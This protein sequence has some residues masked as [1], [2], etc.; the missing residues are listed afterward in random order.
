[1]EGDGFSRRQA[2]GI[3][4]M[5]FIVAMFAAILPRRWWPP[6]ERHLPVRQ[7][8]VMSGIA[9]FLLAIA[10][11]LPAFLAFAQANAGRAIDMMLE[12]TGWRSPTTGASPVSVEAAQA[13]WVGGFPA[14]FVFAFFTPIGLLATYLAFTGWF[15]AISPVF[16]DARGDPLLTMIDAVAL[17][18]RG[19]RDERRATEARHRLEGE[20]VA[21]R[22]MSGASAGIPG[23]EIV[24]VTSSRVGRGRVRDHAGEVVPDRFARRTPHAE[25]PAHALSAQC[26]RPDGGAAEGDSLRSARDN[27]RQTSAVTSTS[28]RVEC[29]FSLYCTGFF[30]GDV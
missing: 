16:D 10:I 28:R 23:A 24:V 3:K 2:R 25:R 29:T 21:D 20:E 27:R 14:I 6:I 18:W 8:A 22:V 26:R 12:A 4:H 19:R 11:G 1:L 9:T 7:A 15:R 13:S 30:V 5:R 17:R